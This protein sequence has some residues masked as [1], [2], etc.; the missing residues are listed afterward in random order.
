MLSEIRIGF[1]EV[2]FIL[3]GEIHIIVKR[4]LWVFLAYMPI[5]RYLQGEFW[6]FGYKFYVNNVWKRE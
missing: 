4:I 6:F 1:L 2:P 5:L 3:A